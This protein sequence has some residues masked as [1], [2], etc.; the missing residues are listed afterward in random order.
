VSS[1]G[2]SAAIDFGGTVTDVVLRR[3]DVPDA[4]LARPAI[5]APTPEAVRRLLDAAGARSDVPLGLLAVT[6]GRSSA[7]PDS[8][9]GIPVVKVAEPTAIAAGGLSTGAPTP[10]IVVSMGTGTAIVVA[11]G[12]GEPRQLVGSGIGGGTLL[13]LS[14]LLLGTTDVAE[15]GELSRRGRPSG[16][17]LTVGDLIGG[18]IGPVPAEATASHFARLGRAGEGQPSREDVAA[19]LTNLV[20]Q[21]ILRLAFEAAMGNAARSIVLLGHLL[22]VPGFRE[23][24]ERVPRLDRSFLRIADQPGFAVARGALAVA[25]ARAESRQ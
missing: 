11:D 1:A 4:L 12:P 9:D 3:D 25:L 23:S 5:G 17:D 14:R 24:I 10:S 2:G 16:C 19:A 8:I 21:A 7:L 18:G 20:S 13:G 6:G 15:I 22:D